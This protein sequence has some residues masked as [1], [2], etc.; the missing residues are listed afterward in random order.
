MLG[1]PSSTS[2]GPAWGRVKRP[3]KTGK[4]RVLTRPRSG[5][6]FRISRRPETIGAPDRRAL[7]GHNRSFEMPA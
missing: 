4:F 6:A 2:M 3:P 7:A 5:Y 1:F